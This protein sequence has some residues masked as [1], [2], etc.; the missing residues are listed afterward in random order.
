[1]LLWIIMTGVGSL[2]LSSKGFIG[3]DSPDK[4]A[5]NKFSVYLLII[6]VCAFAISYYYRGSSILSEAVPFAGL[7][8]LQNSFKARLAGKNQESAA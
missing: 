8:I 2:F 7:F 5:V 6:S 1:M 3:V 4:Q